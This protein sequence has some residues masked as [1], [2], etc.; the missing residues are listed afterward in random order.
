MG[1]SFI[2]VHD[3]G[4]GWSFHPGPWLLGG[5]IPM[6]IGI[7]QVIIAVLSGAVIGGPRYANGPPPNI[8]GVPSPPPAGAPPNYSGS[9]TYR[10]GA[11]QELRK[12]ND[13]ERS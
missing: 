10:P 12:P 7:S 6:F 5:L 13:V 11:A 1:L 8:Y 2:G 4:V 9:Y 3:D